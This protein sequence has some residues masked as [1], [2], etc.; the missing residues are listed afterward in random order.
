LHDLDLSIIYDR[1]LQ[2]MS[3]L[4]T[5]VCVRICWKKEL[6][7]QFSCDMDS[8]IGALENLDH[9][10]SSTTA[11]GSFHGTG[12][13]YQIARQ[14]ASSSCEYSHSVSSISVHI[15]AKRGTVGQ[16]KVT[17]GESSR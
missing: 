8:L 16:S 1:A 13:R 6:Q 12:I 9:N 11:K 14:H 2:L 7:F 5:A 15:N 10:P 3:Q 4:T 17:A